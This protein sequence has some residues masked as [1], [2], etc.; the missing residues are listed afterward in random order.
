MGIFKIVILFYLSL[1]LSC[2]QDKKAS[3][4]QSDKNMTAQVSNNDLSS[5][6]FASGCF[7]CVE[8]VYERMIVAGGWSLV[9]GHLPLADRGSIFFHGARLKAQVR[10]SVTARK[11]TGQSWDSGLL[12]NPL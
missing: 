4:P 12:F 5:A 1:I 8:A 2:V 10:G 7:W 6:Y 3:T 11:K 9:S